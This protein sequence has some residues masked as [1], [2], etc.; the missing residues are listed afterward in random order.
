M[1]FGPRDFACRGRFFVVILPF[2]LVPLNETAQR[3]QFHR[4]LAIHCTANPACFTYP[5]HRFVDEAIGRARAER[6]GL[7]SETVKC[8]RCSEEIT[9]KT[10]VEW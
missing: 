3:R 7:L 8:P 10:L 9:E 4:H 6:D 2:S 5:L 1:R